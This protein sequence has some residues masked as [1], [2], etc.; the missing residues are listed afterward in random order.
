MARRKTTKQE[1][2]ETVDT[3]V[4]EIATDVVDEIMP[5]P[6]AEATEIDEQPEIEVKEEV[7]EKSQNKIEQPKVGVTITET[8]GNRQVIRFTPIGPRVIR[9]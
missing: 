7:K 9:L 6:V 8:V 3:Q 5:A 4:I 1:K 2:I